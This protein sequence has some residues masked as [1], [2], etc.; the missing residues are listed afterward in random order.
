MEE[1]ENVSIQKTG[2]FLLNQR[3][4]PIDQRDFV[5]EAI[6]SDDVAIPKTLDLRPFLQPVINQGSQGTCSAQVA[7]CMQEYQSYIEPGVNLRGD[8]DKFSP[9]FVYNLREEP[10]ISGMSPRETMKIMNK[11]GICREFLLEYGLVQLPDQISTDAYNDAENF[12]IKNYAQISTIEG[13]KK[14]LVKDGVCYICF[15][16]FNESPRMWKA[17]Q[18]ET[19]KGG[20]AVSVVGYNEKGFILRNSWGDRWNDNGYTIFP[21]EDWGMQ[22]EIWTTIDAESFLPNFDAADYVRPIKSRYLLWASA[23]VLLIWNLFFKKG[24]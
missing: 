23:A 13:L 24:Q 9:Q 4:S 14:A 2:T 8:N 5:A 6:Y 7:A 19:T 17:E 21:Y 20:H 15:P 18:G 12:R 22:W 16:V 1:E 11:I 10:G 3:P